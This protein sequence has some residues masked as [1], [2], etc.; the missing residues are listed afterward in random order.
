[1]QS[2]FR[3][4]RQLFGNRYVR[5]VLA[6]LLVLAT[7]VVFIV[8]FQAHPEYLRNLRHIRPIVV[9]EILALNAVLTF[10]LTIISNL[11]LRLCGKPIAFKENFML[12]AYSSVANFFG[13]LQSGPGVRAVYLKTRH[14]VRMRDYT[15]ATLIQ[16]AMFALISALFL[17]GG[18]LKWWWVSLIFLSVG[19]F[20]GLVIRVY[21][22]RGHNNKEPSQFHFDP[23]TIGALLIATLAMVV[24]VT[25]YYFIEL[26][27]VNPHINLRQAIIYSG[28]ANFALFVSLTPDAIGIRESFLVL[29][30]RL[31]HIST[32]AIFA[33]N[34]IDRAVYLLYLVLLFIFVLTI[35]A[36]DRLHLKSLR[37]A[38]S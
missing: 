17:F 23:G 31:H 18:S 6:S 36:S 22:K 35:H 26:K 11:T 2:L 34:I 38:V 29:A 12:T 30:K 7:I 37:R 25:S 9:I 21:S 15:L 33:A 24:V 4:V 32:A 8:F 1:M 27:A 14:N 16:Y 13:P 28:A 3:S 19:V 5:P 20:C 10:I